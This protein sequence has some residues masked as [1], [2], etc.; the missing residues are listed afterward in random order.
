MMQNAATL[1]SDGYRQQQQHLHETTEYG[2]MAQHYGPLVSQIIEKMEITH[3]LDY[4][5]GRRMGLTKTLKV[6]HKLTY[7]GYDPGSGLE[8]LMTPP[9]PAQ[10]VCCIDVL[11][12]I[13][14]DYLENVLNH[15]QELTEA[16]AFITVHTGPA[17]KV[18]PDGRNA[19]LTQKPIDWWLEKLLARFE[20]QTAQK[21]GDHSYYTILSAKPR[22]IEDV[23]GKRL[24]ADL[25]II[26]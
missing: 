6:K 26:T 20:L 13:E 24:S 3:L 2:T 15:L 12:H 18:L 1:I 9:I 19:H 4:G 23:E 8:E 14:P 11:E 22:E 5:C 10:M 16:V 17:F 7:Q 25:K 21:V